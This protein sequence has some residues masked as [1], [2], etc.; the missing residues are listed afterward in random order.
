MLAPALNFSGS[1]GGYYLSKKDSG[2]S[3][4]SLNKL[5]FSRIHEMLNLTSELIWGA[6][7][8]HK[9]YL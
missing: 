6:L 1:S 8:T 5:Y 4:A 2:L 3:E 9:K 7:I